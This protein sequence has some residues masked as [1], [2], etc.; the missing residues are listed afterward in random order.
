VN[1]NVT[2]GLVILA[3]LPEVS[4]E[5]EKAVS[6]HRQADNDTLFTG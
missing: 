6:S 5:A 3:K 2:F 4:A 1:K